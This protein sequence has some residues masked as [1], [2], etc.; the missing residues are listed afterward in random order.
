MK[1]K[2]LNKV[3]LSK[4]HPDLSKEWHPSKNKN[5]DPNNIYSNSIIKVWWKCSNGPDHE[6]EVRVTDRVRGPRCPFCINYRLSISNCLYTLHPELAKS[7]HPT[8]NGKLTPHIIIGTGYKKYW[9]KCLSNENHVWEASINSRR[10]KDGTYRGCPICRTIPLAV[11]NPDIAIQ[12]HLTKNK[13]LTPKDVVA[14]SATY[15]WWK[16]PKGPD[17]EWRTKIVECLKTG[18][19]FC[20]GKKVSQTNS[21]L[22]RYPAL[23][24]EFHPTKN[25]DIN[26]SE[27]LGGGRKKYWWQCPKGSD[28]EW[29]ATIQKRASG[30]GCAI[31]RGLKVVASNCLATTHPYLVNEWHPTKNGDLTPFDVIAGSG[32]KVWWRCLKDESHEW[33]SS[34]K[35]RANRNSGCHYCSGRRVSNSNSLATRYP[36]IAKEWH[37]TKNGNL[38]PINVTAKSGKKVWWQCNKNNT[39]AWEAIICNRTYGYGCPRCNSGWTIDNIREYVKSMLPYLD[40]MLPAELYVLFQQNGLINTEG[41]SKA[42]INVLKTG[43]FPKEELEKFAKGEQSQVDSYI[44]ITDG[45]IDNQKEVNE[46][47]TCLS[48]AEV[49]D[50]DEELPIIE[51]KDILTFVDSKIAAN[52]DKEAIDFFVN[53]AVAKIWHHIFIDETSAI[54]QLNTYKDGLYAEEVKQIFLDQYNGAKNLIIP[55]G[56]NFRINGKLIQP[57]L[58]QRFTTYMVQK[59]KRFGNWSGTGAGKTLSAILS[60][61]IINAE[62]SII[63]CP[64]SVVDGW[65]NNIESIYPD[66]IVITKNLNQKIISG[67]NNYIILN[68]E[69]FQQPNS[70]SKLNKFLKINK[71]DF[72]IIDEIHFSK[73]RVAENISKRKKVITAMLSEA[74]KENESLHVLGMS[75]T[76]VINNLYEGK[77]LIELITGFHHDELSTKNPPSISDCI[78][79]YQK[80]V[81]HGLRWKPRYNQRVKVSIIEVDCNSFTDQI[82]K[83]NLKN[84]MVDLE[85]VLTK[86]KITEILKNIKPKTIVYTISKI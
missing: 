53:S 38:T 45:E 27:I 49:S 25:A 73:Q 50:T 11:T 70:E 41:K 43:K 80:F 18:C 78:A 85:G 71:I 86:A 81:C 19:P 64:N 21:L 10:R 32:K 36:E 48:E 3:P 46:E 6:W 55:S 22:T 67:R 65:K 83:H 75:A 12:W 63:C 56:Y 17:H 44:S 76:P 29:E 59:L 30:Q 20:D 47:L 8:K 51:T 23:A 4:S 14:G 57:N 2:K 74:S 9:W 82:K 62:I 52:I 33:R 15:A 34:C 26:P 61:R 54:T 16:C 42:F 7:W 68:Y 37:P 84:S 24:K 31:C 28:H 79:L 5:I 40:F 35:N 1:D 66:S 72:V 77:S 13:S 60:S 58:M 39:H 69:F